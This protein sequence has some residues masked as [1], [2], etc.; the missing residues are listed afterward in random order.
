MDGSVCNLPLISGFR[1]ANDALLKILLVDDDSIAQELITLAFRRS[2]VTCPINCVESGNEAI[3]YL[4]GERGFADR[5]QYPYPSLLITDLNMRDGDGF[6][7]LERLYGSPRHRI[8]PT[9]VMSSS[10][11]EDDI[12]T[13]YSLGANAYFVKPSGFSALQHLVNLL[14]QTWLL[15]SRP[16]VDSNGCQ[17]TTNSVGKLG[18][19]FAHRA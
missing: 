3:A 14:Y 19:R 6:A 17:V 2:G 10:E 16:V 9:V 7:L 11:D 8:I 12:R 15:A 18:E 4:K 5:K 1:M 13:A